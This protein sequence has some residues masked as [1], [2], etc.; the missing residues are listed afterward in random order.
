MG[1]HAAWQWLY[2]PFAWLFDPVTHYISRGHWQAWGR[3]SLAYL[4]HPRVLDF[5]FIAFSM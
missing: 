2:G 1:L 3:T 4:P 5:N